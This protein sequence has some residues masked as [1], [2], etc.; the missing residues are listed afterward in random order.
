[1]SGGEWERCWKDRVEVVRPEDG[2]WGQR[3]NSLYLIVRV[4]PPRRPM[5]V[6]SRPKTHELFKGRQ[7]QGNATAR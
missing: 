7:C 4:G 6:A 2:G 5:T 3:A 1:M